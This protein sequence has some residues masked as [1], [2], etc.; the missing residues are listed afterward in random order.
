MS[1]SPVNAPF[2][3]VLTS[4]MAVAWYRDGRW[5][6]T[7]IRPVGPLE[8]HPAAHVLHYG[9]ECFE[10]FKAYRHADDSVHIFRIDRHLARMQQSA[11]ALVL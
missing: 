7:E 3:S 2:G 8:I 4:Q 9:S 6:S 1:A 5:S 10:G 11:R